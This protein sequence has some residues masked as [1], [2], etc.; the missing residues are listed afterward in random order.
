MNFTEF[1]DFVYQNSGDEDDVLMFL[2]ND[3][4]EC[5]TF[6]DLCYTFQHYEVKEG[7]FMPQRKIVLLI[8]QS[9]AEQAAP[10][11]KNAFFNYLDWMDLFD[12]MEFLYKAVQ[13]IN[14]YMNNTE[15]TVEPKKE[16]AQPKE[17]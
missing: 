7:I 16:D 17:E 12:S 8:T 13:L 10:L 6:P 14:I 5:K 1:Y 4:R 2:Y 3:N 9:Q 11:T 15:T